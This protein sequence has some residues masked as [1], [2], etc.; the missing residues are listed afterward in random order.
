M[1]IL[2]V[3]EDDLLIVTVSGKVIRIKTTQVRALGRATQGVRLIN[4]E[5]KDRVVTVAKASESE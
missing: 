4:L 1:G 5:D 3:G 2:G